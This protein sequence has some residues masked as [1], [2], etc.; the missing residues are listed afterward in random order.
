MQMNAD[1]S[2][3][4]EVART[5]LPPGLT[6]E[7]INDLFNNCETISKYDI[8]RQNNLSVVTKMQIQF[9]FDHR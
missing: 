6:V 3:N 8:H 7:Q 5:K 1:G 4:V 2:V 9:K